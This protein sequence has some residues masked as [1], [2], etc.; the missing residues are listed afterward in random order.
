[1]WNK[2]EFLESWHFTNA[3]PTIEQMIEKTEQI[4]QYL[5]GGGYRFYPT[6]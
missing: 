5:D 1:M 2:V 6:H 4:V 3:I